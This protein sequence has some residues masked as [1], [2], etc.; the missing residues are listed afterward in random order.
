ML[1]SILKRVNRMREASPFLEVILAIFKSF[2]LAVAGS[3]GLDRLV[4]RQGLIRSS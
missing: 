3:L 2:S 4:I 1:N